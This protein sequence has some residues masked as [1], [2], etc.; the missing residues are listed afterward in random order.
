MTATK[1]R[2]IYYHDEPDEAATNTRTGNLHDSLDAAIADCQ[3]TFDD[4]WTTATVDRGTLHPGEFGVE[5]PWFE[6]HTSAPQ[7]YVGPDWVDR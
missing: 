4:Y 2:I 3:A 6:E 7:A 5:P 1:F